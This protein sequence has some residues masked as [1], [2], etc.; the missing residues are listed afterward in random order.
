MGSYSNHLPPDIE[1]EITELHVREIWQ[2]LKDRFSF[3]IPE[4]KKEFKR[5]LDRQPRNSSEI[6]VF[7]EFG[8]KFIQPVLNKALCREEYHPTWRNLIVHVVS[9]PDRQKKK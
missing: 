9:K 5:Y 1:D 6:Q 2:L 4:W 8:K 3:N 7:V